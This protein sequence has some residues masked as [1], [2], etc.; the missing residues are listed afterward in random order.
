MMLANLQRR[1]LIITQA[2]AL[3][4][5]PLWLGTGCAQGYAE[6]PVDGELNPDLEPVPDQDTDSDPGP[7]DPD[8]DP[9]NPECLSDVMEPPADA[10]CVC[11]YPPGVCDASQ[12]TCTCDLACYGSAECPINCTC[13][14]SLCAQ[15]ECTANEGLVG[16][17][18]SLQCTQPND[19]DPDFSCEATDCVIEPNLV[20]IMPEEEPAV[21]VVDV[22]R[23]VKEAGVL[24]LIDPSSSMKN[25]QRHLACAVDAYLDVVES[26]GAEFSMG[27]TVMNPQKLYDGNG[28]IVADAVP[29]LVG[30]EGCP[31]S[32]TCSGAD[33]GGDGT[34]PSCESYFTDNGDPVS[35]DDPNAADT[36][37]QLF[38]QDENRE[39]H[40]FGNGV[41][42]D[43]SGLE[44]AFRYVMYLISVGRGDEIS[45][46]VAVSDEEA[47]GDGQSCTIQARRY[48][49]QN[50]EIMQSILGADFDPPPNTGNCDT[51]LINFYTY[52][53]TR[54]TIQV[55]AL[56]NVSDGD[57][58]YET[59]A[60]NTGGAIGD[61]Q[62]CSSYQ[63]FWEAVG[64]GTVE[65][66]KEI[67]LDGP[68]DPSTIDL[69]Y[70]EGGANQTVPQGSTD[71]WTYNGATGCIVLH[72]SWSDVFGSFRVAYD[73]GSTQADSRVCFQNGEQPIVN[74]L[75]V[76]T[77]DSQVVPQSSTNGWT[78][79]PQTDCFDFHGSWA[80]YPGP[81]II[82]YNGNQP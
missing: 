13:L 14:D 81:Y 36:L 12:M 29:D 6:I 31:T 74:T 55:N 3:A 63:A 80:D 23:E 44:Y 58:V 70:T 79:D 42:D 50:M 46:I 68:I 9:T 57:P 10:S 61:I 67:C 24:T 5:L 1:I 25:N 17:C 20:Q 38:V 69:I 75:V 60:A 30:V 4:F 62:D 21:D 35:S 37:R 11:E 76:K 71:G 54:Y 78:F 64:T 72:G 77:I 16:D 59:V 8:P 15:V 2:L 65:F 52:F 40:D 28:D 47:N 49:P 45:Q 66:S 18:Q 26:A 41:G 32:P 39:E 53:F 7:D 34:S 51:D 33:C 43:E 82:E 27:V 19:I 56:M 22:V 73:S 48:E